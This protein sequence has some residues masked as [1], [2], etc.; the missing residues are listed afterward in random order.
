M[1][2]VLRIECEEQRKSDAFSV[3]N[4]RAEG[5]D[6]FYIVNSHFRSSGWQF[7]YK[8]TLFYDMNYCHVDLHVS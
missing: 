6:G 8:E 2:E 4:L 1:P 7:T 5:T 3:I